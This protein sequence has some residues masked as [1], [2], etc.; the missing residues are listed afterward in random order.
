MRKFIDV[1]VGIYKESGIEVSP[2][3]VIILS[4][5]SQGIELMSKAFLNP[6]DTVVT[7]CPSFLGALQTFKTYEANLKGVPMEEDGVDIAALKEALTCKPKFFYTIPTY[8]NPTG[9]T[10]SLEKRKRIYELCRNAGVLILEDDP[11]RELSYDGVMLPA[12]KAFDDQNIVVNLMTFSKTISPGLRVGAAVAPGEII[13]KFNILKQ[14][15]DVHTSNLSQ[16]IAMEYVKQG[17]IKPHIGEIRKLYKDKLNA[18]LS[19]IDRHF[20]K[21]IKVTRPTGGLFVWATLPEN[22]DASEVFKEAVRHK[23]AFIPGESFFPEGGGKNTMRLNFSMVS[24]DKIEKG[25]AV[26]GDVLKQYA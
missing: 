19:A 23:V 6:G 8:Q 3:E 2:E 22:V 14:G 10:T 5:S 11:Y 21:S 1:I 17:F 25:I 15:M 12:I 9:I 24:I 26:L 16:V 13:G 18:M 4:G 20:P 7:E